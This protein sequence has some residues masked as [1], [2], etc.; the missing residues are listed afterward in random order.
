MPSNQSHS[1]I[2]DNPFRRL[3]TQEGISQYE[4]GKRTGCSKHAILRLEQGCYAEPLPVIINYFVDTFSRTS[5]PVSRSYLL[6]A[7]KEFQYETRK[8]NAHCL[9]YNLLLT[10]PNCPVGIHPLVYLREGHGINPTALSKLLCISQSTI[11]Y[12]EKRSL[13]QN[14]VPQQLVSAL[15]DAEYTEEETDLLASKYQEYRN[16]LRA[17]KNLRLVPNTDSKEPANV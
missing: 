1:G 10:L 3:R 17:D 15:H 13:N 8:S 7:Y 11:V 14:T 5:K 2:P 16:W 12:F 9:G 6:D 4:L